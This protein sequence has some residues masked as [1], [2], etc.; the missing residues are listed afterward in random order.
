MRGLFF[1][2]FIIFWI[3]QSLI[4][5]ISIGFILAHRYP[6][7]NFLLDPAFSTLSANAVEGA[8]QFEAGGC[9]RFIDYAHQRHED[10]IPATGPQRPGPPCPIRR[11]AGHKAFHIAKRVEAGR[12]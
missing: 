9:S 6:R 4:F 2:I 8:R 3:A 11:S 10:A 12:R 5:V 7:P 1:K